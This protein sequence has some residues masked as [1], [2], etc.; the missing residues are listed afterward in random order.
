MARH[1]GFR[2]V[3]QARGA[4]DDAIVAALCGAFAPNHEPDASA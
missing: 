2:Q 1:A 4:G 3:I